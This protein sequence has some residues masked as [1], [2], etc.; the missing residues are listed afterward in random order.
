MEIKQIDDEFVWNVPLQES[1]NSQFLQSWWWGVFQQTFGR[2]VIRLQ[3]VDGKK[4]LAAVQLIE[5]P[6]PFRQRYFYAPR[7]PI[8]LAKKTDQAEEVAVDLKSLLLKLNQD[9]GATF[10]RLEPPATEKFIEIGKSKPRL[11]ASTLQPPNE[12]AIKTSSEVEENVIF[13]A[14]HEK[15]RYNIKLAAKHGVRA[16]LIEDLGYARRVWPSFW[17]LLNATAKRQRI[18]LHPKEYY[19]RMLDI[20]MPK[21]LV[22]LMIANHEDDIIAAHLLTVFGDTVY[23]LYGGSDYQQRSLMAPYLLHWEG[24]RLAQ[25]LD[26]NFYNLGGISP[27]S[28]K[29]HSWSNLTRFKEGFGKG[30]ETAAYFSYAGATDLVTKPGWYRMYNGLSG[31][32]KVFKFKK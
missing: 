8:W 26:K 21:G 22:K 6:L 17:Q 18:N 2:E 15:T 4:T 20:L 16:R 25:R 7:G 31:A 24:I 13:A 3:I 32:R 14:M 23:Y 28:D 12:L 10:F 27:D 9:K 1:A 30:E 5:Q 19:S 11:L 29:N